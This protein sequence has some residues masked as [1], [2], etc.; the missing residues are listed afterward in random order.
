MT[1]SVATKILLCFLAGVVI[2][3]TLYTIHS[4]V[5]EDYNIRKEMLDDTKIISAGIIPENIIRFSGSEKDLQ[6]KEYQQTKAYLIRS[7]SQQEKTR[8]IY[9][10]RQ[11]PDGHVWILVDSE[12]VYSPD[13]SPPGQEYINITDDLR[14]AFSRDEGVI[15]GPESDSWG[16]FVSGLYPLK[17][18]NGQ[19]I[20]LLGID[21]NA[22]DW[23]TM[24]FYR[25]V[26]PG[27][28][29]ILIALIL[30]YILSLFRKIETDYQQ[31]QISQIAL[32]KSEQQLENAQ[33]IAKLSGWEYDY[34]T[35][36]IA[37]SPGI[38]PLLELPSHEKPSKE[39]F[40]SMV[41]PEDLVMVQSAYQK[42]STSFDPY[43]ITYRLKLPNGVLRWVHEIGH[44]ECDIST[45]KTRI[46]GVIQ[47]IT[48]LKETEQAL[49]ESEER[50]R[51]LLANSNDIIMVLSVSGFFS[52]ASESAK[53]ILGRDASEFI[54]AEMP[55][56]HIHLDDQDEIR[57]KIARLFTIP[58]STEQTNFRYRHGD[59]H[60]IQLEA[61]ATSKIDD[62]RINGIIIN[63]RDI[64]KIREMEHTID[65]YLEELERQNQNLTNIQRK[66]IELNEGLEAKVTE[67]TSEIMML[68]QRMLE[69]NIEIE[70]LSEQKDLFLYQLAHDL[71]TPLTPI[72]GMG[73]F[74]MDGITDP[75]AQEL[76]R[77][78]LASIEY[79]RK[80]TEDILT[81]AQLN[82]TSSLNSYERYD[83]H[84]LISDAFEMNLFLAEERELTLT[85][86]I[87]QGIAVSLSKPYANLVFRNLI[88]NAV[89]FNS[90]K[91]FIKASADIRKDS[92][93]ISI[94]DSGI[95]IT[96]EVQQRIWDELYTGDTA[97]RDPSSK[98][99]GLSITKRIITLHGG[100]IHVQSKGYLQGSTFIVRLPLYQEETGE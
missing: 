79:L 74:L 71:R 25:A 99:M 78:F 61:I 91:G 81:N 11:D 82:Q 13:Y 62:A 72:I 77:L 60:L 47:D 41:H 80:M 56:K 31:L 55:Y 45:H 6:I 67:R 10:L 39:L 58:G 97:R 88:N 84:D 89:K 53:Q 90:P 85:N 8:F 43:G 17:D 14:S 66:L 92:V 22:S 5:N 1:K 57:K 7:K 12:P 75:D 69:R 2:V 28:I 4:A 76:I 73:G 93:L 16:T 44:I 34:Q 87:P 63:L 9:I 21:V 35:N 36:H 32:E 42:A 49:I 70:H 94:A 96:P 65:E 95:G 24:I 51:L 20:A 59:G 48:R 64:S 38:Y 15:I 98:G 3:G 100:S 18:S 23:S 83:L 19:M 86:D 29:T 37:W 27:A 30:T 52:F 33:R 26:G 46:A 50:Y 68:N 40:L 54:G